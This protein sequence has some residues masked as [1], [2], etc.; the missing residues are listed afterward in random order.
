M[1]SGQGIHCLQEQFSHFSLGIST[2]HSR[3]NLKWTSQ[4]LTSF[5]NSLS[6][7]LSLGSFL[8]TLMHIDM[9]PFEVEVVCTD[10]IGKMI[11]HQRESNT[12]RS[13]LIMKHMYLLRSF[14]PST[15]SRLVIYFYFITKKTGFDIHAIETICMKC[16]SCFLGRMRKVFQNVVC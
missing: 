14:A 6:F 7:S 15:A 10:F 11:S 3:M 8:F 5:A 12:I 4:N 13:P 2:S 16:K 1:A 9:S